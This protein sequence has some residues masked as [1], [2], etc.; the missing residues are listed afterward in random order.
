MANYL[1]EN[2]ID[3]QRERIEVAL[4][5]VEQSLALFEQATQAM[6]RLQQRLQAAEK[7]VESALEQAK[8]ALSHK[9]VELRAEL[10][11]FTKE[12][13]DKFRAHL[14]RA[15]QRVS[16]AEDGKLLASLQ[17]DVDRV[18]SSSTAL[19]AKIVGELDLLQQRLSDLGSQLHTQQQKGHLLE[20]GLDDLA[21][22]TQASFEDLRS[23]VTQLAQELN[24]LKTQLL[25]EIQRN[26]SLA[27]VVEA[28]ATQ[29]QAVV[30]ELR[31]ALLGLQREHSQT[32]DELGQLK[33][34]V[35]SLKE[36]ALLTGEQIPK[37]QVAVDE[38][39]STLKLQLTSSLP[40][41]GTVVERLVRLE[42]FKNQV[43]A[44][45]NKVTGLSRLFTPLGES[46]GQK[47]DSQ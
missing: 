43:T 45:F 5:E 36:S 33:R 41:E 20:G 42:V 31:A 3:S 15:Y 19:E 23:D 12:E 44:W 17:E 40:S 8:S 4:S 47:R 35:A 10:N 21:A 46:R 7:Q 13:L 6:P 2:W 30:M 25:Q 18:S 34:E 38:A 29:Q 37:L 27:E 39:N 32:K 24:T 9:S 11:G 26:S 22:K 14:A 28:N 1:D 16:L